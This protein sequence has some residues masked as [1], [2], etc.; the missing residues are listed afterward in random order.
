MPNVDDAQK[1]EL[2]GLVTPHALPFTTQAEL[3][4]AL[5]SVLPGAADWSAA[6]RQNVLDYLRTFSY[7]APWDTAY[8]P[9]TGQVQGRVQLHPA[10]GS[11]PTPVANLPVTMTAYLEISPIATFTTTTDAAGNFQFDNLSTASGVVYIARP[12]SGK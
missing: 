3:D 5:Q 10:D 4:G 12:L 11:A 7:I 6:E 9:G 2:D 1:A 8:R